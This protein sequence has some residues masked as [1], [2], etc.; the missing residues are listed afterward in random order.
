MIKKSKNITLS[1]LVIVG[2]EL[3]LLGINQIILKQPYNL[4]Y[5]VIALVYATFQYFFCKNLDKFT[6]GVNGLKNLLI[7]KGVKFFI[8]VMPLL[9]YVF[10][11][12]VPDLWI[13]IRVTTY[14]FVFLT[15]ETILFVKHQNAK[16]KLNEKIV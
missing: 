13:I 16:K 8:V 6:N 4:F 11:A 9:L 5:S 1:L 12:E 14:Y 15:V 2:A 3:V 7:Y 10:I